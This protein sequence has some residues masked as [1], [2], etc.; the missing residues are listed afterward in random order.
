[1]SDIQHYNTQGMWHK[2]LTP[3][4]CTALPLNRLS[5]Q[6]WLQTQQVLIKLRKIQCVKVG[7]A[8]WGPVCQYAP[9]FHYCRQERPHEVVTSTNTS[10]QTTTYE[11]NLRSAS[12]S[13]VLS[14]TCSLNDKYHRIIMIILQNQTRKLC[15]IATFRQTSSGRS[16]VQILHIMLMISTW[17]RYGHMIRRL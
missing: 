7:K 3:Y 10:L 17:P 6:Q 1:M 9:A 4:L 14:S 15:L 2:Y 13:R 16:W 12:P 11:V 5:K 8:D